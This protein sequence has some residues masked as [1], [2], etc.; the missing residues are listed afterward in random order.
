MLKYNLDGRILEDVLSSEPGGLFVAF[1]HGKRYNEKEI[2]AIDPHGA[3]PLLMPV[4]P[5]EVELLTYDDNKL[6]VWGAFH[7]SEEYRNG[8]AT[9]VQKN[10]VLHRTPATGYHDRE[11][12][13]PYRQSYYYVRRRDKWLAGGSLRSVQHFA[14]AE[15]DR[16]RRTTTCFHT[17][18]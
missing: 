17:G 15:C 3:P 18:R 16:G 7:L 12:R 9:G 2:Y 13:K 5:E 8:A 14:C 4:A 6:G 10:S 11:E 1:I